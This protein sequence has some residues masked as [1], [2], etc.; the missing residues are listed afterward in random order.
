MELNEES[1][2]T[3]KRWPRKEG[4]RSTKGAARRKLEPHQKQPRKR[5]V[6]SREAGPAI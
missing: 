3:R 6:D 4:E 5:Q 2:G 1:R